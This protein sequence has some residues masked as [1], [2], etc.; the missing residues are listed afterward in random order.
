MMSAKA[1]YDL[2]A[3]RLRVIY[4]EYRSG[5]LP[6]PDGDYAYRQAVQEERAAMREYSTALKIC[7]D[8]L[9]EDKIPDETDWLAARGGNTE[10]K[11]D[12]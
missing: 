11:T 4:A 1:R 7:Y 10:P 2:A 8:L 9:L 3:S 12:D 5:A 6:P